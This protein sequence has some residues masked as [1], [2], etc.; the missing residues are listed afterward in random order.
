MKFPDM[1]KC[2]EGHIA[3]LQTCDP[4]AERVT[5]YCQPCCYKD[6]G[7]WQYEH[8]PGAYIFTADTFHHAVAESLAS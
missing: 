7:H 2:P 4:H 1:I 3:I 5:Y 6:R 8:C